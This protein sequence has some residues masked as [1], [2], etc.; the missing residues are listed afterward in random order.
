[1]SAP[2]TVYSD[3]IK[4]VSDECTDRVL[5]LVVEETLSLLKNTRKIEAAVLA[6]YTDATAA[7]AFINASQTPPTPAP[8]PTPAPPA[9]PP[10]FPTVV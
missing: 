8:E 2:N 6:S 10:S 7:A 1:M 5:G 3:M 4:R 9:M